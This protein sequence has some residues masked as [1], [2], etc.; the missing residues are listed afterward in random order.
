ML[1]QYLRD[2]TRFL[3]SDEFWD[4]FAEF[5]DKINILSMGALNLPRKGLCIRLGILIIGLFRSVKKY[6]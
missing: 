5:T 6:F 4:L 3:F 2:D 1:V